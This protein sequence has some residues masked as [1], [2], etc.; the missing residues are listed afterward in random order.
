M[1]ASPPFGRCLLPAP[2]CAITSQLP[3]RWI[4]RTQRF[5]VSRAQRREELTNHLLVASDIRHQTM[6]SRGRKR[7]CAHMSRS[8]DTDEH[9]F[10]APSKHGRV[11]G[12]TLD[13][14]ALRGPASDCCVEQVRRSSAETPP[15]PRRA[16]STMSTI[17]PTARIAISTQA[18]SGVLLSSLDEVVVGPA[19]VT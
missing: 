15:P 12:L 11:G 16:S 14:P 13:R 19:T 17:S 9:R 1:T 3:S 10:G 6:G 18:Q 2:R 8:I 7:P 5:Q 4:R